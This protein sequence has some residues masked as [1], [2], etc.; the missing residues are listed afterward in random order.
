[1]NKQSELLSGQCGQKITHTVFY[2][3]QKVTS[4]TKAVLENAAQSLFSKSFHLNGV[5]NVADLGCAAG[6]N[7]FSVISTVKEC[8]A[9]NCKELNCQTPELQVYF[10]D[11]PGNDFNTLFK[12]LLEF[13]GGG[14]RCDGVSCYVMGVPGSFH[15]RLFP[16]NHL[17]LVHSSYSVQWQSQAPKGLSSREGLALNKGKIYVSMTSPPV[18]REAYLSQFHEDFT[19]FLNSRSQ[20]VLYL[21]NKSPQ[22]GV[23]DEVKLDSFN[24]PYYIPSA[25]EVQ[26]VVERQGSFKIENID[27]IAVNN[28]GKGLDN[29]DVW[30]RGEIFGKRVRVFTESMI[31]N[32]FGEEVLDKIYEKFTRIAVSDWVGTQSTGAITIVAVLNKI[33][34]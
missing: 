7:T 32:Q 18:V 29:G 11:L 3:Q 2:V 25:K 28:V 20:E 31:S 22:R 10:N 16:R 13:G 5:F 8:V 14:D 30:V 27:T 15:S 33:T 21:I 12:G 9:K 17:H 26:D 1:M 4:I 19:N 34:G 24:V 23:I 6:P